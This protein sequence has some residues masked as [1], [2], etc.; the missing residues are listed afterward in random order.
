MKRRAGFTLLE[1]LLVA[2]VF[3]ILALKISMLF[4]TMA[5]SDSRQSAE[6]V[7]EDLARRVVDQIGFAVMGADRST[8]FPDPA[9]PTY[10]EEIAYTVS[11]GVQD[12]AVVWGDPE[13]IALSGNDIQVLWR[14]NPDAADERR[15]VWC[16][17]VRPFL[18]GEVANGVDD[19][20][21]GLI[22]ER[23]LSFTL[24]GDCV[25]IRL[26]LEQ[27]RE[28]DTFLITTIESKVTL[29]N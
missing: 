18:E 17:V 24:Q 27:P 8:L 11:L 26:T 10:S 25:S 6:I 4:N 12:G 19:N 29:R 5:V 14:S 15:V 9:S 2:T 1:V 23:G 28:D 16:N 13:S 20:G 3:G 21:N 7:L 22:D